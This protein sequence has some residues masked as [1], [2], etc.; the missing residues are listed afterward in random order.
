MVAQDAA[1]AAY[2]TLQP[3]SPSWCLRHNESTLAHFFWL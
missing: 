1:A 2:A 3:L